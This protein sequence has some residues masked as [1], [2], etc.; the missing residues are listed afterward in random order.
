MITNLPH[1]TFIQLTLLVGA[2]SQAVQLDDN[3]VNRVVGG[4]EAANGSVPHQVSLQIANFGH[5]CGG[6]IIADRWV[7]TAAHCVDRQIPEQMSVLVGTN[8]LKEGGSRYE[9]EMLIKHEYYNSPQFHNDIA[10][11]RLKSSLQFTTNVK[12]IEYSER[13][14]GAGQAVTLTGW[15]R[16]SVVGPTPT[17][18]QTIALQSISNDE[19]KQKSPGLDSNVDIGHVCTLT[20][21]GEG[22]C[23]GDSGGPLTLNGKL[24]GVVNFGVPCALG[25]PDAYARVSYYHEWIRTTIAENV[26]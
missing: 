24:I 26:I 25:Y 17:K 23:N 16:I 6:A 12:A 8:S 3:Y 15:G 11:I 2:L 22:A 20:R 1:L 14:V 13:E 5:M 9:T 21:S 4:Q 18:L 19:C 7:L 10:L